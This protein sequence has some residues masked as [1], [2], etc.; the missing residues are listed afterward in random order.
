M[1]PW[2][3]TAW[4]AWPV[5]RIIERPLI[6]ERQREGIALAKQR[7]AYRGHK[8][9]LVDDQVTELRRRA[10]E[11]KAMLACEFGIVAKPSINT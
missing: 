4:I 8:N 3:C 7:G 6:R 2:W 9:A 10:G 11:Q 1:I 5:L